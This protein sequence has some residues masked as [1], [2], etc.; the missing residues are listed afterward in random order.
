[1][2]NSTSLPPTRSDAEL[3]L[4]GQTVLM[5]GGAPA[6]AGRLLA[7]IGATV[8]LMEPLEGCPERRSPPFAPGPLGSDSSL[9]FAFNA[10][11]MRSVAVDAGSRDGLEVVR[12]G[13]AAADLCIDGLDWEERSD[14]VERCR[15]VVAEGSNGARVCTVGPSGELSGVGADDLL[16]QAASG[17]MYVSGFAEGEPTPGP[18]ELA[19]MQAALVAATA[20]LS[21]LFSEESVAE[22]PRMRVGAQAALSLTTLQ[23]SN[24]GFYTWLG[25][26]PRRAGL[27]GTGGPVFLC[28]DGWTSFTPPPERWPA[29]V[30][31]LDECG[32][33][34]AALPRHLE[35]ILSMRDVAQAFMACTSRLAALFTKQE[36]YHQAQA[37]GLLAMPV[38]DLPEVLVDEH[39]RARDFFITDQLGAAE[40]ASPFR[41]VPTMWRL[42]PKA[43]RLGDF[44]E[45]FLVS[46]LDYSREE[47]EALL[48]IGAISCG[49]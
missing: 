10:A 5:L 1:M 29:Y 12:R 49:P 42:E 43:P 4:H 9:S 48:A 36:F 34:A 47:V 16:I 31:W 15:A 11:G 25:M 41:S 46:S 20:C 37:R 21:M 13:V 22:A 8:V 23:T 24:P 44:T 26:T 39:L 27:A 14:R 17:V 32:I 2:T 35:G 38:N 45:E 18:G 40:L 6:Y 7:G 30:E 3:P 33:E 19:R 28:K